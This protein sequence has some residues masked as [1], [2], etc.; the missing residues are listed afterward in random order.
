MLYIQL[1]LKGLPTPA[2]PPAWELERVAVVEVK[3]MLCSSPFHRRWGITEIK[4][5][6]ISSRTVA[7][8]AGFGVISDH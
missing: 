1:N 5:G 8:A 4:G 2:N 3:A 6:L 7:I